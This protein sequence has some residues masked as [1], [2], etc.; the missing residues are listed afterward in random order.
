MGF[1]TWHR[2]R[3][4]KMVKLTKP[5]QETLAEVCATVFVYLEGYANGS[6]LTLSD[7]DKEIS[8]M[9]SDDLWEKL[10]KFTEAANQLN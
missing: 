2:L 6:Q 9:V 3:R 1:M 8:G 5:E 7:L 10:L 4:L